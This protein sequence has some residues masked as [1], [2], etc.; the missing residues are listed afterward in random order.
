LDEGVTLTDFP[1]LAVPGIGTSVLDTA[2]ISD[3]SAA[4]DR[5][6]VRK[7]LEQLAAIGNGTR[8]REWLAVRICVK[9]MM[10]RDGLVAH[11]QDCRIS[12]GPCG[13]PYIVTASGKHIPGIGDCSLSH[14]GRFAC[15]C[16]SRHASTRV[17][18]DIEE[19]SPRLQGLRGAF[20]RPCDTFGHTE[21][22]DENLTVLWTLKEAY[23]KAIGSGIQVGLGNLICDEDPETRA[24]GVRTPIGGRARARHFIYKGYAIG[25]C[26]ANELHIRPAR[27]FATN[28]SQLGTS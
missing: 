10:L 3:F 8:R 2:E 7:E 6:L 5:F 21:S 19:I 16:L 25:V 11:A 23:S 28:Q 20:A 24:L 12:K 15:A 26:F 9:S 18:V 17:G 14:K 1:A 4:A 13:R 22:T 27:D